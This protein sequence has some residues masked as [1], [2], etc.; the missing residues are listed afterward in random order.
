MFH[1]VEG[2]LVDEGVSFAD[3]KGTIEEFLRAF[4]EKQLEV[5]FRPSFFPSPSRRPKWTSSA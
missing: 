3:L 1:Q 2:L 4:F 5:R